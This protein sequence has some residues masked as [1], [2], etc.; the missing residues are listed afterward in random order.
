[1]TIYAEFDETEYPIVKVRFVEEPTLEGFRSYLSHL[2]E[3]LEDGQKHALH[4]D[5]GD[6]TQLPA[7]FRDMQARW[8]E[9]SEAEFG[10][11]WICAAFVT[12]RR[13]FRGV[14]QVLLWLHPPYYPYKVTAD[15]DEGLEWN[16]E[17]LASRSAAQN[18]G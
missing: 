16:R 15:P 3:I 7:R 11:Y 6:T 9:D 8:I 18:A 10:E 5:T 17:Q 2:T 4:L 14:L 13:I 12:R 1:M